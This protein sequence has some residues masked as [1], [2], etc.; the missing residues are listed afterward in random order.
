MRRATRLQLYALLQVVGGLAVALLTVSAVVMLVSFVEVSRELGNA[1]D[2]DFPQT[3]G[4]AWLKTP[5]IVLKLLPFVFLFGTMGAFIRMNRRAELVAMRAAGLSAWGFVLPAIA[6]G[7]CV[8][9]LVVTWIGPQATILSG[10][11]EAR[12]AQMLPG[13][14]A[15]ASDEVWLRQGD[16][17]EQIV[18]HARHRSPAGGQVRLIGVSLFI[19]SIGP[20]GAL[21]FS[22]RVEATGATLIPGAWRLVDVLEA[23]P[24]AQSVHSEQLSLPSTLDSRMATAAFATRG[25]ASIWDLSASIRVAEQ[26]GYSA[27][28]FRLHRQQ[29][30]ATPVMFAAMALLAAAFSLRLVRLGNLSLFACGGVLVGFLLFFLDQFCTVLGATE[31]IPAALA[32]WTPPL[33]VLLSGAT[34]L[35][36]TEDG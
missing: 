21:A 7:L 12:R 16:D 15:S 36:Y 6:L 2:L 33:L 5:E 22:R 20:D 29:L 35:C 25:K 11:F 28:A 18:I 19:Q 30:L 26:A 34:T 14:H 13:G 4:L 23:L 10:Q 8:G 3:V 17:R 1:P 9:I 31:V 24:G 32:A 27:T